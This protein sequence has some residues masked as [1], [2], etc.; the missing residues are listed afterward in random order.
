MRNLQNISTVVTGAGSG[1]GETTAR[2][3]SQKG[4]KVALWDMNFEAAQKIAKDIGGTAIECDVTKED[5]VL[6]A[7]VETYKAH[8]TPRVIVNCAGILIGAR[9]CGRDGPADLDHFQKTLNV[10]VIGTY[11]VM[12]LC[13]NEMIKL[14]TVTDSKERGVIVNTASIA[15]FEGQIGQAAYSASKGAIVSMTLPAA[16]E[17]GKFGV[18][19]MTIAPGAVETPMM[20][21][22]KDE[23]REKIEDA[24]P[25]PSRMAKPEE[26]ASLALHIVENEYLNGE[27]IRLDGAVRL[28]AK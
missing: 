19:V 8:G 28:S 25:F 5:S 7:L 13:A 1:M 12:R 6:D 18:R 20:A 23:Y 4:A 24:I 3:L 21:D 15:A 9:L 27:T 14:D 2:A 17:L 10:N 11:N 16:R 22:V 26:F